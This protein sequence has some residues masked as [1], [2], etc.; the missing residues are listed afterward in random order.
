M[1]KDRPIQSDSQ[2]LGGIGE[3]TVQLILKKYKWTADIIKSD[4]GE[5]I[6]CNI[7]IDNT[8]T[9][10]HLRCQVKSTS[11][12]STFLS[13]KKN[14]DYGVS[15][16][17]E[18]LKSWMSAYFPVILVVYD[19][20]DDTCYW[21]NPIEQVFD[22]LSKLDKKNPTINVAKSKR[23]DSDTKDELLELVESFYRNLLR[24]EE[25]FLECK[26]TPVLMPDYRVIPF[27][28]YSTSSFEEEGISTDISGDYLELLPNWT[29]VLQQ[30]DPSSILTSVKVS[31]YNTDLE[32]FL[33]KLKKKIASFS[34]DLEDDEWL[35]FVLSPIRSQS[36]NSSWSNELT[37]WTSYSLLE[38]EIIDDFSH[39]FS[40]PN[41]FLTQVSRRARSW[42][43]FHHVDPENDVAI[44][45][46]ACFDI[47]PTIKKVNE[48]RYNNIKGQFLLWICKQTEIVQLEELLIECGLS[49]KIIDNVDSNCL[50]AITT[51]MFE[52]S[53]GLFQMPMNWRSKEQG[54]VRKE[55]IEHDLFNNLPGSEYNG[56]M[57]LVVSEFLKR[58]SNQ[59]Q[60]KVQ[61][62]E[63]EYISGLPASHNDR[64]ISVSRFQM[65]EDERIR[66]IEERFEKCQK[67][68]LKNVALEFVLIDDS[69]NVPI[70]ELRLS[71]TPELLQSS[72]CSY[73][74]ESKQ[75]LELFD[76]VLPTQITT[77]HH[78]SDTYSI[79]H[80]AGEI[81]FEK[82]TD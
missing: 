79:L 69:W 10:Y 73:E 31:S 65:V 72:R 9:N 52:P 47:T 20:S 64:L 58:Y 53:L 30:I 2:S 50:L 12:D 59:A 55:M 29:S 68:K 57:P 3:T 22:N 25:S 62:T 46:F 54:S 32:V 60:E 76:R 40:T 61:I 19:D 49:L 35:C 45:F 26:I 44:Q 48:T 24:L 56:D 28:H 81:G 63:M 41:G 80:I 17:R 14:G 8:R 36:S 34:Y 1:E 7:F 18:T 38:G 82:P 33:E 51:A 67:P 78:L 5:D 75:I 4:F 74:Q 37:Y 42:D 71:W 66:E 23:L 13:R 6:D 16:K 27:H 15:V 77:D 43:Y 39:G 70:Y 21:C 11:K